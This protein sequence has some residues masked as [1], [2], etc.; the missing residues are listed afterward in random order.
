MAQEPSMYTTVTDELL[1]KTT[2]PHALYVV[3]YY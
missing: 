2:A 3:L 1:N